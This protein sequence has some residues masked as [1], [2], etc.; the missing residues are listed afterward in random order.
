MY[1]II[2]CDETLSCYLCLT[3][4]CVLFRH[5]KS[6]KI[7]NKNKT[8]NQKNKIEL[9]NPKCQYSSTYA[10]QLTLIIIPPVSSCDSHVLKITMNF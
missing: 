5:K 3:L 7:Y 6:N 2:S 4:A 9:C 1:L 10:R 8:K